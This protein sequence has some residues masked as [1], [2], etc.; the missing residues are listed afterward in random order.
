MNPTMA[1]PPPPSK[2]RVF[3]FLKV[4]P[5]WLR[6]LLAIVVL[7]TTFIGGFYGVEDW[8][9][10][11]AW[12]KYR[13]AAEARGVALDLKSYIPKAVPDDQNFAATPIVKS[14]FP[15]NGAFLT[16][17]LYARAS[18]RVT[19]S[20]SSQKEVGRHCMDLVAWQQAFAAL[21]AGGLKP[22]QYFQSG[23]FDGDSRSQAAADVLDVLNQDE[24]V[25]AQL[26]EASL[27]PLARYPVTYLQDNPWAILLPHLVAIKQICQRLELKAC[28]EL[29]AG[30]SETALGDLR[31]LFYL[32]DSVHDEPFLISYLIRLDCLP[33]AVQPIWEGLA[34]HRWTASEARRTAIPFSTD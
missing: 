14:W 26:R 6:V 19:A 34:E 21:R 27:R 25:F 5:P 15:E 17:D 7:L 23:K 16:N 29:A 30:H 18:N 32:A 28:A 3:A 9:G 10:S 1:V 13:L 24:T 20:L 4:V 12:N 2:R 33:M 31:L 22:G 11:H 8:R